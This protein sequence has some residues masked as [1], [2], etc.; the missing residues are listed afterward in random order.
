MDLWSKLESRTK[1]LLQALQDASGKM[2]IWKTILAIIVTCFLRSS[3]H[4]T[5][6]NIFQFEEG[7]GKAEINAKKLDD[8]IVMDN[9]TKKL[10]AKRKKRA[11]VVTSGSYEAAI[12]GLTEVDPVPDNDMDEVVVCWLCI[13]GVVTV[14][15]TSCVL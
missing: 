9:R 1:I 12:E 3:S 4:F 6:S 10:L 7:M 2:N 14:I 8:N 5:L 13:D 11:S 15:I